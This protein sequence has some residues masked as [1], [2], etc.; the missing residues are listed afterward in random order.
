MFRRIFFPALILLS[1]AAAILNAA[2]FWEKKKY[3]EWSPKEVQAMLNDSPWA[4]RVEVAIGN[5]RPA[6]SGGANGRGGRGAARAPGSEP[7]PLGR[8]GEPVSAAPRTPMAI[9]ILRFH[10]ALP[11]KQAVARARF[12]NEALKS[13]EA[14][15]MLSRK[16]EA[17]IIGITCPPGL[18]PADPAGLKEKAQMVIKGR[19]PIQAENGV[20]DK[21]EGE[22]SIYLIF[23]KGPNPIRLED[24][25]FEL[26]VQ[27]PAFEFKRRFKLKDMVFEGN[28]EL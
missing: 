18:L 20:V 17:I 4:R 11:I 16:E 23:P 14:A 1:L 26:R 5:L 3:S 7:A 12:G 10:A 21:G 9:L 27:F 2:D 8:G 19:D 25:S 24:E 22:A 13:P 15:K 28:L 6:G